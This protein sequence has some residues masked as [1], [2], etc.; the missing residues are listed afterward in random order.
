MPLRNLS[1]IVLAFLISLACYLR[2]ARNR[3]V[4]TITE[5][6]NIVSQEYVDE[7]DPRKLF[8]GAMDGMIGQLDE[9]SGYHPPDE[10]AQFQED[11]DQKF[12]GIGIY[13]GYDQ[14]KKRIYV[15]APLTGTP[16]Y[17]AGIKPDD[18]IVS[19]DGTSTAD[20]TMQAA[21]AKIKGRAGTS[22]TMEVLHPG[23][24][25]PVK[26]SVKRASIAVDS[27]LGD[28]RGPDNQWV[29]RLAEHP[30][31]G[32]IRIESFGERTAE[33]LRAALETYR[34]QGQD[35]QGLI[36]DLRGNEGG[37]LDSA[38]EVCD[39]FLD[40]GVIV[41]TVARNNIERDREVAHRGVEFPLATPMVV[42]VDRF[43]ASAS[44]IVS[45]CLQ[46]HQRAIVVGQRSWGKGTVQNVIRMEGGRSAIR[47][48]IARY[49]RP[50]GRNIHKSQG[51]K[52][53]DDWGVRPSEGFDLALNEDEYQ[54]FRRERRE[55]DQRTSSGRLEWAPVEPPP[56]PAPTP[57][58]PP[59]P[60]GLQELP[61]AS[62]ASALTDD[63]QLRRAVE[64]LE[65]QIQ[66]GGRGKT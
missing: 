11:I 9:Y 57:P 6:M 62:G 10:Y 4:A 59:M 37:L 50:S 54:R 39:M 48:T 5:A 24:T 58:A 28:L 49:F 20:M 66:N 52:D 44:E 26:L 45:A 40:E 23:E 43:S 8:E 56:E 60:A 31:L 36:L 47:L 18:T 21:T 64:H 25:T 51:A 63:A 33:E 19:I 38:V 22:V 16:A 2:A 46:D 55:R 35:V 7:V 12:V 65:Q 61:P 3:Y 29:Y 27:V 13:V 30:R 14:E 41:R 15:I 53:E 1:I 34:E 17:E 32:Y 42:M